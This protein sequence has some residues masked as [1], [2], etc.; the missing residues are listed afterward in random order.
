MASSVAS[1]RPTSTYNAGSPLSTLM[2]AI[3]RFLARRS[4]PPP[5]PSPRCV[6]LQPSK[7]RC[8]EPPLVRT[9]RAQSGPT[10]G[11]PEAAPFPNPGA[12]R[13]AT[14]RPP[15]RQLL[16][17]RP[18]PCRPPLAARHGLR[19][20]H[21]PRPV[22]QGH[23]WLLHRWLRRSLCRGTLRPTQRRLS[24]ERPHAHHST[25]P[26]P[27]IPSPSP[28][29]Q[30]HGVCPSSLPRLGVWNL[31]WCFPLPHP[32]P[33]PRCPCAYPAGPSRP[34]LWCP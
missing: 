33:L 34:D 3:Q 30:A 31:H 20:I 8:V 19:P 4:P 7:A 15:G 1:P 25:L 6:P 14:G 11:A 21:M 5:P 2:R 13:H 18:K 10:C 9:R 32:S 16:R 17:G 26:R 28:P 22:R 27:P 23:E 29:P 12:L 24:A